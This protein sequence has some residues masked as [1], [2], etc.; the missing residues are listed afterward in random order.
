MNEI[1]IIIPT[2]NSMPELEKCLSSFKDA[3]PEN[4]IVEIIIVDKN[5]LDG[6]IEC[7]K[8]FNCTILT[9][10]ISLGSARTMGLKHAKTKVICFID[11]DIVL[12][13]NWYNDMFNLLVF[14]DNVGWI[15][16]RTIDDKEPL[17]SEKLYK[18][19]MECDS[20]GRI[21]KLGDRAYTN[22]TICLRNPLLKANIENLNAWEDWVLAQEMMKSGYKILE[23]P[24][25]CEHLRSETYKKFGVY[26]EAWGIAGELKSKGINLKTLLRPFWFLYWGVRCCYHFKDFEHFLFNFKVFKSTIYAILFPKKF[27]DMVR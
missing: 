1:S 13:K 23:V 14:S 8:K 24:I 19:E 18:M 22:N 3:F 25:I 6:T 20:K 27:F 2:Y 7:A 9:N 16:G 11:S 5:S 4:T 15:Y 26:T 10:T 17:K 21:L 12:P